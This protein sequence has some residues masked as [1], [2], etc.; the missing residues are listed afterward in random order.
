M[1]E[2]SNLYNFSINNLANKK[3][4]ELINQKDSQTSVKTLVKIN[5]KAQE[6]EDYDKGIDESEIW[7][8][9]TIQR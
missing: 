7:C 9:Y 3:C 8:A 2:N 1:T 6:K 4:Y 5:I